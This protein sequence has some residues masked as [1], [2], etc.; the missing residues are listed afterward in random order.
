MCNAFP[1]CRVICQSQQIE[2]GV[3]A[4]PPLLCKVKQLRYSFK[5]NTWV[6]FAIFFHIS[7]QFRSKRVLGTIISQNPFSQYLC[8]TKADFPDFCEGVCHYDVIE[9]KP[10]EVS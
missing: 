9:A 6:T 5:L 7:K 1:G 10:W 2:G 8:N 3:V 4:T